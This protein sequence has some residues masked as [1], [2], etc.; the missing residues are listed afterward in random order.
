MSGSVFSRRGG[1]GRDGR[2]PVAALRALGRVALWTVV[3]ML[4]LRGGAD[5]LGSSEET[6][7]STRPGDGGE[8]PALSTFAIR[9]ARTYLEDPS[10]AALRPLLAAGAHVGTGRPPSARGAQVAQ[11]EVIRTSD[12]GDGRSVVTVACELRDSRTLYLAVPVV[13]Q[14]AGEAAAL[15]APSIVAVPATAGADPE[16]PRPIAGPIGELV[17]RFL[18][19]YLSAGESSEL[20]YYL[21]PGAQVVPL[22]GALEPLGSPTVSQL[23]E[24][25]GPRREVIATQRVGEPESGAGWPLAYRLRVVERGGRWYVAAVEGAVA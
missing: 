20:S 24:G 19:A 17:E 22:G 11:A 1:G 12:V 21:A 25:E 15:G 13:R 7:P 10:P 5:L 4:L 14:G 6:P 9:F 8:D 18:P 2:P 16:R 23:G 3:A